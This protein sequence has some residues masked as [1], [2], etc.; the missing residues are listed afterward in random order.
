MM[1]SLRTDASN[2]IVCSLVA[3]AATMGLHWI[4]NSQDILEKVSSRATGKAAFFQPPSCPFYQYE[5][6]RLSPYGDEIIPFLN[7]FVS[8]KGIVKD[9]AASASYGFFKSYSGKYQMVFLIIISF[10]YQS[11][12]VTLD[13]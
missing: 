11:S 13:V 3:D 10:S 9:S 1:S 5:T 4:Y 12:F 7:S 8:D 2:M 6:G